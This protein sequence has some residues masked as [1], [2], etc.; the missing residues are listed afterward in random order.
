MGFGWDCRVEVPDNV[1]IQEWQL[2]GKA[3]NMMKS[4]PSLQACT[5]VAWRPGHLSKQDPWFVE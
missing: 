1:D 2:T 4:E 5:C 3:L